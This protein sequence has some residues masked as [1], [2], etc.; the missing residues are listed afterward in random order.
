MFTYL[1]GVAVAADGRIR[2]GIST[3]RTGTDRLLHVVVGVDTVRRSVY[4]PVPAVT[5]QAFI[6]KL[7]VCRESR[8]I[9]VLKVEP[10]EKY[11]PQLCCAPPRKRSALTGILLH[12]PLPG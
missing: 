3:V 10:D 5:A 1:S 12:F 6:V 8:L 2:S 4:Q 7:S 9:V 11:A